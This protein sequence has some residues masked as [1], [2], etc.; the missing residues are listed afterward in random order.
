MFLGE[1][2]GAFFLVEGSNLSHKVRMKSIEVLSNNN[3]SEDGWIIHLGNGHDK[4]VKII[5]DIEKEAFYTNFANSLNSKRQS[6]VIASFDEQKK[7]WRNL[8]DDR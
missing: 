3:I 6:A 5:T 1:I 8:S 2:L 4:L 7:L